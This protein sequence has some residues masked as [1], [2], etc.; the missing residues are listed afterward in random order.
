MPQSQ[1]TSGS[2]LKTLKESPS[3][4]PHFDRVFNKSYE[5][6][7]RLAVIETGLAIAIFPE[8]SPFTPEEALK[9]NFLPEF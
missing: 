9:R 7:R 4:K 5:I 1:T 2:D 3:L 6:A 8:Q